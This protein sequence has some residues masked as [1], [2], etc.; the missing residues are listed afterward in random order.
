[1]MPARCQPAFWQLDAARPI[2]AVLAENDAHPTHFLLSWQKRG[3]ASHSVP[4]YARCFGS[5]EIDPFP[6]RLTP[7][8]KR[9][10]MSVTFPF[11]IQVDVCRALRLPSPHI[12]RALYPVRFFLFFSQARDIMVNR[13]GGGINLLFFLD[14]YFN[15][16][17]ASLPGCGDIYATHHNPSPVLSTAASLERGLVCRASLRR[18]DEGNAVGDVRAAMLCSF[19]SLTA[20]SDEWMGYCAGL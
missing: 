11:F 19:P 7:L 3:K 13:E 20:V 16:R 2:P 17:H 6:P 1:M 10:T 9:L 8:Y 5:K 14:D 4:A 12:S 18:W 15:G